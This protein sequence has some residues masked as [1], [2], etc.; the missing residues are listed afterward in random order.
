MKSALGA[1][2]LALVASGCVAY[3]PEPLD[4]SQL[5]ADFRA[6]TLSDERLG[7][8]LRANLASSAP[9]AAAWP[10]R[11][12]DLRMLTLAA[13]FYQP[14]LDV[15]RGMV[16][17]AEAAIRTAG[18]R[19]NPSLTA[20]PVYSANPPAGVSPWLPSIGVG[21]PIETAGKRGARLARARAAAEAARIRF[22]EAGWRIYSGVRS[23]MVRH[24]ISRR[25]LE[26]LRTE[27]EALNEVV[28]LLERRLEAG[29]VS[30][31]VVDAARVR[32]SESALAARSAE[33]AVAESRAALASAVG[34]P[35]CALDGV[36]LS[37][38]AFDEL[39]AVGAGWPSS[40]RRTGLTSR[41]DLRRALVDYAVAEAALRLEV[42]RQYPNIRLGPGYA[43]DQG[44][45]EYSLGLSVTL[46]ILNRNRG[47][48]AEAEAGR[49]TS[50]ASFL[51]LQ[52]EV[53]GEISEALARYSASVGVLGEARQALD[54]Q[55][56]LL[57]RAE[58]EFDAGQT[59]SLSLAA[60][61]AQKA[62]VERLDVDALAGAR[63]ALGA[64]EDAIM[65]PIGSV[66]L[67]GVP[68]ADPH[69]DNDRSA[70]K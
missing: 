47:P 14:D 16:A 19:P 18:E 54:L 63:Q 8:F 44:Q 69:R 64:L 31:I 34:V 33:G 11:S 37:E 29:Q 39:P 51:A 48:I 38:A 22:E 41:L 3:H 42:A 10:P 40:L 55:V 56:R 20:T 1:I 60:A 23:T 68:L 53:T 70:R 24:I 61:R 26:A 66:P 9:E 7:E 67:P 50:A 13:F 49:K 36:T 12:W 27:E 35:T 43:Y 4:P 62:V 2:F 57:A 30:A 25:R 5:E 15:A 28:R 59:G 58:R 45:N 46:P 21:I 6:R 52:A 32:L 17:R 65:R